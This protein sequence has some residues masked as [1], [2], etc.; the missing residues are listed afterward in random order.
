MPGADGE[1]GS[2]L[3]LAKAFAGPGTGSCCCRAACS[4]ASCGAP[5]CGSAAEADASERGPIWGVL[6]GTWGPREASKGA[7]EG[8]ASDATWGPIDDD[9]LGNAELYLST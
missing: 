9:E 7:V 6:P 1:S 8:L 5:V 3:L 4:A 2:V